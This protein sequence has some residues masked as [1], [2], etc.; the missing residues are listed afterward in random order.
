M[1]QIQLEL[2]SQFQARHGNNPLYTFVNFYQIIHIHIGKLG[3][4]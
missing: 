1:E 2:E 4:F 3:C